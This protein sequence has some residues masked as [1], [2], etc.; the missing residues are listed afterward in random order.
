MQCQFHVKSLYVRA[1]DAYV[2]HLQK[3]RKILETY[4]GI[5]LK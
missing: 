2:D 1:T 4:F 5:I 3:G